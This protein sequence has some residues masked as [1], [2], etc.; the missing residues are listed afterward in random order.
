[1]YF[2]KIDKL[3]EDIKAGRLTEK[4]RFLY[5]LIYIVLGAV[6]IE[7]MKLMPI[8]NG[9]LWDFV[10]SVSNVLL[11]LIGTI[12]AFKANRATGGTDFLGKYFSIG[13][14]ITIRFIGYSIPLYLMLIFYFLY[15]LDEEQELATSSSEVIISLIWCALL[16]WRICTHIKQ[17]NA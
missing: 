13:L 6:G 14:V 8:E 7:F 4:N 11:I 3:K 5:A 9:N 2:W 12:C 10:S 16:Y 1:M 17:V 15:I